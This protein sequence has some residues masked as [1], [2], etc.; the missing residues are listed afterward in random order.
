MKLGWISGANGLMGIIS[1]A[2]PPRPRRHRERPVRDGV[3]R[4]QNGFAA[5]AGEHE[6]TLANHPGACKFLLAKLGFKRK[7]L[8]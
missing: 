7:I 2:T 3:A 4:A 5:V 1:S 6:E 8:A